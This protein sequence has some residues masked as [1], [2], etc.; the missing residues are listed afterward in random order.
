[1]NVFQFLLLIVSPA[2]FQN[3]CMEDPDTGKTCSI[4]TKIL[5]RDSE[6]GE[7]AK[8]ALHFTQFSSDYIYAIMFFRIM[9]CFKV[10]FNSSGY[11]TTFVKQICAEQGFYPGN[12]FILKQKLL[13][14]PVLTTSALFL[15]STFIFANLIVVFEMETFIPSDA[16]SL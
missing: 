14:E 9:F 16:S 4:F 7:E 8:T 10:Y 12:W 3:D 5:K 11:K 15:C 2:P 6:I 13:R 1:M